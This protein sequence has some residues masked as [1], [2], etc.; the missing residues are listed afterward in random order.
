MLMLNYAHTTDKII[1]S[2]LDY[3]NG[4][5]TLFKNMNS[6]YK[7]TELQL[8]LQVSPQFKRYYP[9]LM[10]GMFVP[11]YKE[12]YKGETKSFNR[13]IGIVKF[14][15]IISL[16]PTCMLNADLSWRSKGNAENMD[17]AQTWQINAG[18]MKQLGKNWKMKLMINDIFNSARKNCFTLYSGVREIE[19]AKFINTRSIECTLTYSFNT[20]KSKYKGKGAGNNEKDRL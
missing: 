12:M 7:M 13:V 3:G 19:M 18:L 14:N 8:G 10:V 6:E 4:N 17:M 9:A 5:A 1:T 15:N 2:A 20:I 11:F 16:T